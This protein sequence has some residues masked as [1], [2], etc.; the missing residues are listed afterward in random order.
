[1]KARSITLMFTLL[2]LLLYGLCPT[3]GLSG[4]HREAKPAPKAGEIKK[5]ETQV[6]KTIKKKKSVKKKSKPKSKPKPKKSTK[7]KKKPSGTKKTTSEDYYYFKPTVSLKSTS[8]SKP[9]S[10]TT[11][12]AHRQKSVSKK[13]TGD[14]FRKSRDQES[15]ELGAEGI[16]QSTGKKRK[17]VAPERAPKKTT[18]AESSGAEQERRFNKQEIEEKLEPSEPKATAPGAVA[19]ESQKRKAGHKKLWHNQKLWRPHKLWGT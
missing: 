3:P 18:K 13:L 14:S 7:P 19:V 2:I 4:F 5:K 9:K 1:M 8:S 10:G 6:K 12:K 17:A 11:K 15:F 16:S